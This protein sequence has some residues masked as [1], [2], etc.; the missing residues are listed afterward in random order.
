[1]TGAL[2]TFDMARK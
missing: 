2:I 1:M